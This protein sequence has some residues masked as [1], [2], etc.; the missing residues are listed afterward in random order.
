MP[1][2]HDVRS[3]WGLPFPTSL[4]LATTTETDEGRSSRRA[5]VKVYQQ[6][7][8]V[9]PYREYAEDADYFGVKWK[10]TD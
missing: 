7:A 1:L 10:K 2:Q 3:S 5:A 4:P 6:P 8:G 9:D